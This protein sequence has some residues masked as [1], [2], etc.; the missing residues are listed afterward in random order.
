MKRK[1]YEERTNENLRNFNKPRTPIWK[2]A[3]TRYTDE[4]EENR[5][6]LTGL[7][8]QSQLDKKNQSIG[9]ARYEQECSSNM[10]G[11]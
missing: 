1:L 8:S 3:E 5:G 2:V 11:G 7:Q 4:R 9:A 10:Q 6:K